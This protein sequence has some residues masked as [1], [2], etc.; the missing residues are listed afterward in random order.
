M[1][2]TFF[3]SEFQEP[4]FLL[5]KDKKDLFHLINVLRIK[6]GEKINLNYNSK[7]YSTYVLDIEDSKVVCKIIEE[8]EDRETKVQI[9]LCQSLPKREAWEIILEKCTEIGVAGFIP[10]QT[11]RTIV[12][13]SKEDL[14]KK[15]ERWNKIIK[16]TVK[17]CGR[18]KL[19]ILYRLYS[20]EDAIKLAVREDANILIAWEGAKK[21]LKDLMREEKLNDKIFLFIGPEGSFA[22]EEIKMLEEAKSYFFNMGPRILKV[23]TAAIVASALLLYEKGGLGLL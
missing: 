2:P 22:E 3:A 8:L 23:E 4:D 16:E 7:L 15:Y 10:L 9:Y 20:L 18:N 17:Q 12:N 6:R 21:S 14:I 11:Q 19:P 13:L 5:I 1:S